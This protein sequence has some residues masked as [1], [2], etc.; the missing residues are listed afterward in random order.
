MSVASPCTGICKL[1]ATGH[2][3]LGCWRSRAEIAAWPSLDDGQRLA[4]LAI[5]ARR[6]E[7]KEQQAEPRTSRN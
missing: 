2:Y 4:V 6:C 7:E 5:V 3:C 1:D